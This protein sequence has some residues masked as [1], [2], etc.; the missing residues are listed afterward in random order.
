MDGIMALWVFH[1][2]WL[3]SHLVLWLPPTV[4][5]RATLNYHVG[6]NVSVNV[7]MSVS[8]SLC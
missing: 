8:I 3:V 7:C 2:A 5:R 6:V 1:H 4:Q